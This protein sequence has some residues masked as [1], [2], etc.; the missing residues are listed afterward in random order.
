[1]CFKDF[2]FKNASY[3]LKKPA[4]YWMHTIDNPQKYNAGIV[5]QEMAPAGALN[6]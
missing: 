4:N 2:F 5:L 3:F 6:I 1:M